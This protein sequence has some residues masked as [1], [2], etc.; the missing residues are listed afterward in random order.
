MYFSLKK[1][2]LSAD[3]RSWRILYLYGFIGMIRMKKMQKKIYSILLCVVLGISA[4]AHGKGDIEE[5]SVDNLS[6]WQQQFD[7]E[8][9]KVGKYNILITASDLGGNTY[10]DG[11]HN[12]YFDPKSD[13]PVCGITN[14]YKNMR[15]VGNLNIVGTCTDDDGVSKVELILDEGT[16]TEKVVNAKGKEFWSYYLE[17]NDLEEG[18]HTIK[19]IGYDINDEPKVSSPVVVKWQLDRKQPKTEIQDRAMGMLVSGNVK[20]DGAVSDGNGIKSLE[21]SADNGNTFVPVKLNSKKTTDL[22]TFS[23]SVDTKKFEDGPAVLWFRATDLAGSV[24]MYSFLYFIDNAKPDVKIVYPSLDKEMNGKITVAGYAKDKIGVTDLSWTF[25]NQ[26]GKIDLVPGNPYWAVDLDTAGIKEKSVKFTIRA[27]D[28]AKNIVEVSQ[29][30]LLNKDADKPS[31]ENFEPQEGHNYIDNEDVFVRGIAHDD[32]GIQSVVIQL[33]N[34]D[35]VVL[36]TNGVYYF[37]LCSTEDL[38]AGNHKITVAAV[39]INGLKSDTSV[40][41]VSSKGSAP[42]FS[43]ARFVSGKDSRIDYVNG[44]EIHPESGKVFN[45]TATS[46]VGIKNIFSNFSWDG[47]NLENNVDLKNVSS[48]TYSLPVSPDSPKGLVSVTVKAIDIF[49]R[50]AEFKAF[51]YV[52]N[53]TVVKTDNPAV[54]FDDSTV[55]ED[56]SIISNFEFPVTGYLIGAKAKSVELYPATP[57]AT[58]EL[59]GNLIKLVAKPDVA[60]TSKDVVVRVKTDNGKV[61]ESKKISFKSGSAIPELKIE[62]FS[63]TQ[64]INALSG[65]VTLNGTATCTTGLSSL[66]YRIIPVKA[67]I[68]NGV[69][70]STQVGEIKPELTS[71]PVAKSGAFSFKV[72]ADSLDNGMHIVEVVAESAGGKKIARAVALK[73]IPAVEEQE[74]KMPVPT[75]PV[76]AWVD[77]FDVYAVGIYQGELDTDFKVFYRSEMPEGNNSEIFTITPTEGKPVSSKFS[78]VKEYSLDA[79]IALVNDT[80]YYSGMPVSLD[81]GAKTGGLM[82]V[83]IDT[84]AA[85]SSVNYEFFGENV[86]GGELYLKGTAKITKPNTD[87]PSRWVA[88]I[89]FANL[90]VR[91]NKVNITIKAATLEK[92]ISGSITVVRNFDS[93]KIN[94]EEKIYTIQGVQ[95][96][97]NEESKSFVLNNGSKF[98]YYAN[99]NTPLTAE[100]VSATNGLKIETDGRLITLVAEKEGLYKNVTL[101]IKDKFGDVHVSDALNFVANTKTSEVHLESPKLFEWQAKVIKLQGTAAHPIG[102]SKVEYSFDSGETWESFDLGKNVNKQGVTFS[103][104]V[105]ISNM[106]DGLIRIDIRA[107]DVA[108]NYN[109]FRTA[110]CKDVTPPSVTVV[111][112]LAGD[113]INGQNLIVFDAKDDGF[114]KTVE[115]T[116]PSVK[117]KAQIRTEI[118]IN[119]LIHTY[120]GTADAPLD[121]SMSFVFTDAAGNATTVDAWNFSIQKKS[122]LP[123]VEIQVPEDMQVITRDFTISGVV[124]DDDGACSIYYKI[125]NDKYKRVSTHEVYKHE[126][127]SAEYIMGSSFS[128]EVPFSTMTDNEHTVTVYAV[129]VNGVQGQEISRTFR[130]SLEEPK[131]AV[132]KP[133]IDTSVRNR[134]TISGWASDKNGIADVKI[135]LDNGNSYNDV[136]GTENWKY[137]IDT[138]AIPGGTRVVFL[139][140]TDKYGIQGLY[141]SLINIDNDAPELNLEL[142][143]DESTTSGVVFFSG[144]TYDNV[145]V[146][147]LYLTIRSLEKSSKE[148]VKK[149]KIDRIIGET[150][151]LKDLDNGF[152]NVELTVKDKAGNANNI[153]RNIHLK[154]DIA[155]ATVD[156]LYPLNGEHKNGVF[157]IY[158]QSVSEKDISSLKLYIDDKPVDE[159]DISNCGFFKFIVGSELMTK[160]KHKYRVDAFLK[161]GTQVAS[162]EQ[163]VTYS[164]VGPWVTIDSIGGEDFTCGD[165][166][167]NRPYI[168]G[169]AGYAINDEEVAS[170]EKASLAA[171]KVQKIEIS[172]DNGKSFKELS[173][174]EKWMY[175]IENQD[176]EEGYHFFVIR[177]TMKNGETAITKTIIQIDNTPPTIKLISPVKGGRYNQKLNVSGLSSDDVQLEDLKITLR[178]GDKATYEVPAFIQGLYVDLKFWGATLYSVGAGLTFFDDVVKIQLSYGQFTQVQRDSASKTLGVEFSNMRYGGNVFSAKILANISSIPFSYFF[179]NDW[180]WLYATF[181]LGADFSFF[182]ATSSGKSQVLS[183]VLG[184]VEFPKV[185]LQNR[186]TFSSFA[187]Y[188]EGSLW[189]IPTDVQGSGGIKNL[190]P[191]IGIGIRANIF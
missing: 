61:I 118:P 75:A 26:S 13:L 70:A 189:F 25:G 62:Q 22:C 130:I 4:F 114:L 99:Y 191:Q 108:S 110:V 21:L 115:Y 176:I 6:S 15:V 66:G 40:I 132:E 184:Q 137:S 72:D 186:N 143:I 78:V 20:F 136:E 152:Y 183:A 160:G 73:K 42:R 145:E 158:G 86:P 37:K 179:G 9:K 120:I 55:G 45:V 28:R 3:I 185:K 32:D 63:E 34:K 46:G 1:Q 93:S 170:E 119:P 33:D 7:L 81:Y 24:G 162:R 29:N 38:S 60:G 141:S 51:Y 53:T 165:F 50:V 117:G 135:S 182:T 71:I 147:D 126:D 98:Y 129:D 168:R 35:P 167:T 52:T 88:E 43:D 92:K 142:P 133:T 139:K 116:A 54:V 150:V 82:K 175:R 41:N 124:Y 74:E 36:E 96:V 156:I 101:R 106:P 5:I 157:T 90:P 94:D 105:D 125:D 159:T 164:P 76:V 149:F 69:I 67:E 177:A 91:V 23:V 97:F 121:D 8:N 127:P 79:N 85:V 16:E 65:V 174:N 144:Y 17:T 64:S 172:F 169:M 102:I 80:P 113:V 84:G 171:K 103:K 89:P 19:V 138:R 95:T 111:E 68:Q 163:E 148:I 18:M 58:A 77:S 57:F 11:P 134:I 153:S 83:Y 131:G 146:T 123:T 2:S 161:D 47:G 49:E 190:I 187:V 100:L 14:P 173:R 27:V 166:A 178:K 107:T 31:I 87:N 109:Y 188:T 12:I 30:I 48:Y 151:D 180:S 155:P 122:D 112:P 128:I 44:V 10:V 104:N 181:A 154:K 59:E 39:D 56:G 140:I